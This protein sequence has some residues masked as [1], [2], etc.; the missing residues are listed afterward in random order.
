[1]T[2]LNLDDVARYV[3]LNIG[4]FHEKRIASLGRLKLKD[5]L[6]RKNPWSVPG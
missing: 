4:F 3:E 6:K 2:P 5:V 1:M